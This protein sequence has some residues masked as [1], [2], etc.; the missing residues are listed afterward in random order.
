[1]VTGSHNPPD[2]NGLKM[3]VAGNTLS[4]D[5]IQA[6]RTR[7]EDGDAS[8]A[9]PAATARTTSGPPTSSASSATSGSR[10]R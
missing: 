6:L 4:G 7:I 10:G 1:M 8:R 2:Y 9:A 3:V 5:D